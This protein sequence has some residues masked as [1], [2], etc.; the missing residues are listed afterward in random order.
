M[1]R[2]RFLRGAAGAGVAALAAGCSESRTDRQTSTRTGGRAETST[3]SP[4]TVELLASGELYDHREELV[5]LLRE[6]GLY[7]GITVE[8]RQPS[9]TT[10]ARLGKIVRLLRSGQ[11]T[12]TLVSVRSDHLQYLAGRGFLAPL[13]SSIPGG[14]PSLLVERPFDS[15]VRAATHDGSLYGFP[16]FGDAG[17]LF[18]RRDLLAEAGY[19]PDL[20]A[21]P[22]DWGRFAEVVADVRDSTGT[23]G[24]YGVPLSAYE[25]L[26]CCTF[27]EVLAS[28]GGG[29]FGAQS[30]HG[31]GPVGD[32]PV[33][34]DS[35]RTRWALSLL[36]GF[37]YGSNEARTADV[38]AITPGE[39]LDWTEEP[40]RKAFAGGGLVAHRNWPYVI[41]LEGGPDRFGEDLGLAPLPRGVSSTDAPYPRTGGSRSTVASFHLLLNG[42]APEP[43]RENAAE[44]LDAMATP[45]FR[46]GL[47]D[48][49]ELLPP[50]RAD[51]V[52]RDLRS[53]TP[54]GRYARTLADLFDRGVHRSGTAVWEAQSERLASGFHEMLTGEAGFDTLSGLQAAVERLETGATPDA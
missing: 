40:T 1:R 22:P 27:R 43:A 3:P 2:R 53:R 20:F 12:P 38:P 10:G 23:D 21:D 24:G 41:G 18:Y 17:G 33:T 46:R 7:D 54:F 11:E 15:V 5:A 44:V 42:N 8:L 14:V 16:L 32:R 30:E 31:F 6:A 4:D 9:F 51:L 34:V 19:D 47:F 35:D 28:L 37:L 49:T 52:S 13:E 45:T 25:G 26:S 39:A 29:Y 36:R 48:L 50:V